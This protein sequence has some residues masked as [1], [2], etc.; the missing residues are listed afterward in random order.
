MTFDLQMLPQTF[1]MLHAGL[2]ASS[3]VLLLVAVFRKARVVEN[4]R[5]VGRG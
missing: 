5:K 3:I 4:C 2:A 1:D